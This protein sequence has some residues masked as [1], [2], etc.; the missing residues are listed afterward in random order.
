MAAALRLEV[1]RLTGVRA[2][3]S[4]A[5]H[6]R[7]ALA[8][9]LLGPG[10]FVGPHRS[11]ADVDDGYYSDLRTPPLT[12]HA[13][14]RLVPAAVVDAFLAPGPCLVVGDAPGDPDCFGSA[15]AWARGRRALSL[16]ADAHVAAPPPLSIRHLF[17]QGEL[18]DRQAV[19]AGRYDTVVLVDNDGQRIG[20]AAR[21]ALTR[22]KRVVVVDHHE[23]HPTRESLGLGPD[24]ELIVWK[25]PGADA[26]ALM[27][28]GAILR[29]AERVE[30][31]L[32][33]AGWRSVLEP[34]LAAVYSDT[35]GFAA[36]R[37]SPT[38]MGI[39]RSVVESRALDL[40]W[41]LGRFGEV[42][43]AEI[44]RSLWDSLRLHREVHEGQELSLFQL[45]GQAL[46]AAW[47]QARQLEPALTWSDLYF[48][49]LDYVEAHAKQSGSAATILALETPPAARDALS[50][51]LRGQLPAGRTKFSILSVNP[52]LAVKMAQAM[53]GNGKPGEAGGNSAEGAE[54]VLRG[55]SS[56][57]QTFTE[58][59]AALTQHAKIRCRGSLT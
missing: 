41:I 34:I 14:T 51:E 32:T 48:A 19:S 36:G 45:D 49:T 10:S 21:E 39:L 29:G 40:G 56:F 9:H 54:Q 6:R 28:L 2:S 58:Q 37:V 55:A 13:W 42:V 7:P 31:D 20:P 15:A 3:P 24:T 59:Q 25:Q 11:K 30:A 35:R 53:G 5:A 47:E 57:M 1:K 50:G 27:T 17:D 18:I 12:A 52:W 4:A 26:A 43:P 16:H 38:T 22:A 8:E 23:V 44:R 33:T 46:L